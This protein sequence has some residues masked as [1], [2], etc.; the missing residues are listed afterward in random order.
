MKVNHE[1]CLQNFRPKGEYCAL[2]AILLHVHT[3]IHMRDLCVSFQQFFGYPKYTATIIWIKQK[4]IFTSI[5]LCQEN[6]K[7]TVFISP[8]NKHDQVLPWDYLRMFHLP[9]AASERSLHPSL[10]APILK[11]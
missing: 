5:F 7:V 1:T 6:K 10:Y 4:L 11:K 2:P 8:E 3:L 9:P